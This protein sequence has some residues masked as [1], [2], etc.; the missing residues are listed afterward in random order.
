[1]SVNFQ[2]LTAIDGEFPAPGRTQTTLADA[3]QLLVADPAFASS[4]TR[5]D[6]WDG[7]ERYLARFFDL[8]VRHASLLDDRE[9]VRCLWLGGSYVSSRSD[10]SNIDV[11]VCIDDGARLA[12]KGKQGSKWLSQAFSREERKKEFGVSPLELRYRPVVSVFRSRVTDA[13]DQKYLQDRG[14]WDE[15]WQRCRD[16]EA[17]TGEPTLATVEAKRGYL[18]VVL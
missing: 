1:M 18:E 4:T 6:L 14:G 5:A 2:W 17:D 11:T 9:L 10:P 8:E 3:R 12:L 15:W 13:D 16:P 7:L